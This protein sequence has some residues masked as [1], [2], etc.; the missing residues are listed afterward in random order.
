MWNWALG[1]AGIIA[2]I[3]LSASCET[4]DGLRLP[5]GESVLSDTAGMTLLARIAHISDMQLIDEESPARLAGF[6][7]FTRSAW[8]PYEAY[9]TQ[10]FDGILRTVNNI[11][12]SG[13]RIDFLVLTGDSCDNAQR[14]EL[15]W[16]TGV[17]DG[18]NI[19]PL[20]GPDDR[21]SEAKPDALL[22]P[23]AVFQAQGLY[24][25][26]VHGGLPSI[27]WYCVFGNHDVY[28][29][30]IFPFSEPLFGPRTALLPLEFRPDILLPG[31]LNPVGF[32]AYGPVSPAHPGP[33]STLGFP[34]LIEPNPQR[35]FY[36]R[37]EFIREMFET[38]GGP[39]GHG[40]ADAETGPSWYSVSPAPGLRL[41]GLDT[42][43]PAHQIPGFLYFDGS[44]LDEQLSFLRSEL[45]AAQERG[46]LAIV[47]SHHPSASLRAIYGTA[48]IGS[49]FRE[50]LN[51][52]PNVILHLAG[53]T[54][55]NRVSDRGGYL[56]IETA[57][58]LDLPQEGRLVE[59]WQ[60]GDDGAIAIAYE[61][62]S[63]LDV[64]PPPLG[65]DP[66]RPLR[67]QAHKVAMEDGGAAAR[68]KALDPSG[69]DPRGRAVDRSGVFRV[70]PDR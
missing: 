18:E 46:E 30:G 29:I 40:F 66:L 67:A 32:I 45:A 58:T 34:T 1:S 20:T 9:S 70:P 36:T 39:P 38:A 51:S 19:D 64:D 24:R 60:S 31:E 43:D 41:I 6:S 5:A 4:D 57:S 14:N 37:R 27:P 16:L 12:A 63:H 15:D 42:C 52:F 35:A 11:H 10:L 2:G 61:V 59:I 22:D 68:Q 47:A 17:F 62:F 26:G 44:I 21:A 54:H 28:S 49:E 55:R 53:H 13:R 65:E 56:E 48:V 8:R 25:D 50:V 3:L 23:H 69:A 33:P 7:G